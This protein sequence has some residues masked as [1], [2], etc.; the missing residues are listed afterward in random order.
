MPDFTKQKAAVTKSTNNKTP[1]IIIER[2]E[3]I[4]TIVE[5]EYASHSLLT[6]AFI[7]IG[8]YLDATGSNDSVAIQF[9]HNGVAYKVSAEPYNGK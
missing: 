7:S 2:R 1:A 4:D 3:I 8:N 9:S 6:A 5:D